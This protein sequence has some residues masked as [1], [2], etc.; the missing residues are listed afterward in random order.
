MYRNSI[1]DPGFQQ[2]FFSKLV[3]VPSGCLEW[4]GHKTKG[5]GRIKIEDR[6][7][8]AH[9]VAWIIAY[10]SIPEEL[11]CLHRCDNPACCNVDHLFLGTKADN[12]H[13]RDAK[14]RCAHGE[15]YPQS[16]LTEESVI[17]IRRIYQPHSREFGTTALGLRF[18]VDKTQISRVLR[19]TR[20]NHI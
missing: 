20:W 14:G 9:R 2:R 15:Q 8:L 6:D 10:G 7:Y 11:D 19:R 16:K 13:D 1:T 18:G 5:Y 12:N 4:Q 3:R 17:E